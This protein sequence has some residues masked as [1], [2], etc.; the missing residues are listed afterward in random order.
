MQ[1][2]CTNK[3]CT[4]FLLFYYSKRSSIEPQIVQT[5]SR[6]SSLLERYAECK[7]IYLH[8]KFILKP[9]RLKSVRFGSNITYSWAKSIIFIPIW[10]KYAEF[11]LW[12]YEKNTLLLSYYPNMYYGLFQYLTESTHLTNKEKSGQLKS[13][14]HNF[15]ISFRRLSFCK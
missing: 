7:D 10:L 8:L 6:T 12:F 11:V 15:S 9:N 4:L 2:E 3:V 14:N 13:L 5:E 1:K